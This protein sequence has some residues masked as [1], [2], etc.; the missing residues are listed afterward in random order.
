MIDPSI[1]LIVVIPVYNEEDVIV[2][3]LNEWREALRKQVD[4]HRFLVINDGS[5]DGTLAKLQAL[6]WPELIIHSHTNRGHG[7]SC[8][9]G[10]R[11]AARLG[12]EYVFQIDSDGQ[13][14]PVGF[15]RVW[16]LRGR[17]GAIY[18]RRTTRADG[19]SRWLVT[20]VLRWVLKILLGTKLNDTNVPYRLYAAKVAAETAERI[21]PSFELANIAMA[22]LLEPKGFIEVPIHFRDR[23][24]GHPS[25]KW[26][27]FAKKAAR[28]I[29]DL[30]TLK[31]GSR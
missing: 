30:K 6:G 12:A 17:A 18:G 23:M 15:G 26:H 19:W 5:K 28:L 31:N 29:G 16:E 13:C 3:V 11:E 20:R 8:L 1:S 2:A 9:V 25:V 10:Y 22:L 21:A 4:N 27:G 7:Q 24:G 14:D